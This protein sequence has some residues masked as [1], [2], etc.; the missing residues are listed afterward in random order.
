MKLPERVHG[1]YIFQRRVRVLSRRL[2]KLLPPGARV[3]D[4]GCGDGL[5]DHLIS[6]QRPDVHLQG[7]DVLI[8]QQTHVPVVQFDGQ[9]IPHGDAAFDAVMFV[10]VLHHTEEPMVLLR[11][12]ARVARRAIVIKDHTR[13]GMLAG[14][15]LRFMDWVGNARHGVVLPYNYWPAA[16]W[17]QAFEELGWVAA[18]RETRLGLYSWPASW[19]F[20]RSLHFVARLEK[21][22]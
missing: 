13:D 1:G 8:R 7:I 2:A 5:I 15:T 16:R 4:V 3:L 21:K 10:D 14:P 19:C 9:T 17:R 22:G 18:A 11:E 6:L 20:D 12:A